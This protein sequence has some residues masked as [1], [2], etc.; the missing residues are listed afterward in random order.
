MWFDLLHLMKVMCGG[1]TA[2][3]LSNPETSLKHKL[4]QLTVLWRAETT[5]QMTS[6]SRIMTKIAARTVVWG[7]KHKARGPESA[8][9]KC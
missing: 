4:C 6:N 9:H 5:E 7:A 2:E 3:K 8:W 1:E